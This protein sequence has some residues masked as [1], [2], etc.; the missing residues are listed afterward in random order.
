MKRLAAVL[1]LM[2]GVWI[3]TSTTASARP[4]GWYGP[5]YY[6]YRPYVRPYYAPRPYWGAYYRPPVRAFYPGVGIGVG[7]PYPAY[8]YYGPPAYY[9]GGPVG[10]YAPGAGKTSLI[11]IVIVKMAALFLTVRCCSRRRLLV[12]RVSAWFR[13]VCSPHC[14]TRACGLDRWQT[15]TLCARRLLARSV[16][17]C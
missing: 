16:R 17:A 14:L 3:C 2:L 9:Y 7:Y 10:P 15:L 12:V 13:N 6:A 5:G 11:G 8:G 4:Y 1:L